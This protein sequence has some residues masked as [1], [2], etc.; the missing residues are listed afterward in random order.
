[1]PLFFIISGYLYNYKKWNKNSSFKCFVLNRSKAYLRPYYVLC[2]INL[3]IC[4]IEAII[5]N[6]LSK[7]VFLLMSRWIFGILYV[8]PDSDIMPNCTPLWFLFA[9]FLA[10]IMFYFLLESKHSWHKTVIVILI[11]LIETVLSSNFSHLQL[12]GCFCAALI[13]VC[14]MYFGYCMKNGLWLQ[15][16]VSS[17][18]FLHFIIIF[19]S[20]IS[21]SINRSVGI[22]TNNLGKYPFLFWVCAFGFS[23]I[24]IMFFSKINGNCKILAW[25]GRNTIIF[26][27][28]NYLFNDITQYIW[29]HL[30]LSYLG[31]CPWY[32]KSISCILCISIT[33][34]LWNLI[35][36]KYPKLSAVVGF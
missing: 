27:G 4:L 6:G 16:K 2:G 19:V 20:L 7:E 5:Q 17:N 22:S 34:F 29:S 33:I 1:M 25:F 10:N 30:H 26:M 31:S 11:G 18:K 14:C 13:G 23:Y 21:L 28:F 35:K 32:I 24:I 36:T 15:S 3:L 8:Y 9:L 12:P